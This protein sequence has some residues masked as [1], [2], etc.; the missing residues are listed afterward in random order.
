MAPFGSLRRMAGKTTRR[1]STSP[2]SC[3][4]SCRQQRRARSC[5]LPV[6]CSSEA[7]SRSG[8]ALVLAR[9]CVA[10]N[11]IGPGCDGEGCPSGVLGDTA[12]PDCRPGRVIP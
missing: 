3:A 12:A 6:R 1:T 9:P 2:S 7:M 11:G 4:R 10:Q 8:G 5:R